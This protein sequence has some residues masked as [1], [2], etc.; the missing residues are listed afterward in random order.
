M[1]IIHACTCTCTRTCTFYVYIHG[2]MCISVPRHKKESKHGEQ[3]LH[4][5]IICA[6]AIHYDN[7]IIT[8][9]L[10]VHVLSRNG[11]HVSLNYALQCFALI[12]MG[13]LNS[14]S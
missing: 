12:C 3:T 1:Y 8:C 10:Y 13:D 7:Y 2:I 14:A 11:S 5:C 9:T 6:V 4:M